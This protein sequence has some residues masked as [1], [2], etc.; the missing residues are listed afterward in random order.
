MSAPPDSGTSGGGV[1]AGGG[2]RE[3]DEPPMR[4]VI[5]HYHHFK[6]AGTSIDVALKENLGSGW[7]SIEGRDGPPDLAALIAQDPQV[8][9]ISS[10]TALLPLPRVPH[11]AIW[12][13]FF[14]RHPLERILSVYDFEKKQGS[15]TESSRFAGARSMSDYVRWRLERINDR[16][17]RDFHVYRLSRGA[18]LR[19]GVPRTQELEA[20]QQLLAGLGFFGIVSRFEQSIGWL[21]NW[22][23]QPFPHISLRAVRA[24]VTNA[25]R[26]TIEERVALLRERLGE[27]LFAELLAANEADLQ[28]YDY[29]LQL[30]S[31]RAVAAPGADASAQ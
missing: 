13:I 28:L 10:H 19:G 6:N 23:A 12:P 31:S 29:A 20:A 2:P 14:L 26:A 17:I 8:A 1:A 24:N 18:G 21:G 15:V 22:L 4:H 30:F 3:G 27:E 25:D 7:R 5:V 9:A 16:A 11:V